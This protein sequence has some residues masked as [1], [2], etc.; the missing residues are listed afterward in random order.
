MIDWMK[1]GVF[2]GVGVASFTKEKIE[3]IAKEYI[4]KGKISEKEGEKLVGDMLAS[5]EKSRQEL[6]E[7]I[8]EGVN[9]LL[10]KMDLVRKEDMKALREEIASLRAELAGLKGDEEEPAGDKPAE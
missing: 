10:A 4:A 9:S 8:E 3:E 2:A 5:A 7:Q 1:K 6:K